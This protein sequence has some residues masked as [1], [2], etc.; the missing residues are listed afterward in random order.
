MSDDQGKPYWRIVYSPDN[1]AICVECL[2]PWFDEP[3][4]E[5]ASERKFPHEGDAIRYARKLAEENCI[6]YEGK[7]AA[8][9]LDGAFELIMNEE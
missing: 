6:P 5:Y 8:G 3:N 2:K 9:Y 7:L 1:Q 4:Y